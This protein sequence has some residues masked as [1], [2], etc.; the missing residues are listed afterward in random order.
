MDMSGR[1]ERPMRRPVRAT[2]SPA[3]AWLLVLYLES[4]K[5]GFMAWM[6]HNRRKLPIEQQ[7]AIEEDLIDLGLIANWFRDWAGS[8]VGRV[9]PP[10]TDVARRSD[11]DE[12]TPRQ[13]ADMLNISDRHVRRLHAQGVL[14]GRHVNPRQLLLTRA[15]VLAYR[16]AAA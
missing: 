14:K 9:Q 10:A 6:D 2:L 12:L 8:D 3:T 15:S 16:Q 5:A 4:D 1:F 13:A 7:V 11:H